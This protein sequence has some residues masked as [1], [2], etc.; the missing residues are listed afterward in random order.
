MRSLPNDD[1]FTHCPR[2]GVR[3]GPHMFAP[4]RQPDCRRFYKSL[5][6]ATHAV[7]REERR[8]EV[9]EDWLGSRKHRKLREWW[10]VKLVALWSLYHAN[11]ARRVF[12]AKLVE[13]A[14]FRKARL[15][16]E[17][18]RAKWTSLGSSDDS[19]SSGVQTV[20]ESGS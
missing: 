7:T 11:R 20:N 9:V 17:D 14:E 1:Y 8:A 10:W 19:E 2:C 5:S 3:V 13:V 4:C 18:A 6:K 16:A 12:E 15:L